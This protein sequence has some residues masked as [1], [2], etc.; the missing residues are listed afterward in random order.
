MKLINLFF[1]ILKAIL[2]FGC[3]LTERLL[4]LAF[5]AFVIYMA[6]FPLMVFF[7]VPLMS[8]TFLVADETNKYGG[9]ISVERAFFITHLVLC[10]AFAFC[11]TGFQK[12]E[13]N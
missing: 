2:L 6:S 3:D 7:G 12:F 8:F 10:L 11:I 5:V 9:S 13:S 4:S 1:D